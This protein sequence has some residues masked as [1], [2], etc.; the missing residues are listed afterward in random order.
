MRKP[1]LSAMAAAL[2]IASG[3]SAQGSVSSGST[4]FQFV[5][6][7]LGTTSGNANLLF[8]SSSAFGTEQLF[9][10]GWSYNQ[11]LGTSN[12]LFSGLDTPTATYIGNTA[13]PNWNNAGAGATGFARWNAVM[14]IVL[15]EIAPTPG[16][17]VPGQARVD[18]TLTFTSNA[19]NAANAG[20]AGNVTFNL[21]HDLDF[22]IVGSGG[23]SANGDTF[24]VL[25]NGAGGSFIGRAFDASGSNYA[26]FLAHG[27][28]RYEFNTGSALR[29]R[30]GAVS[31]GTGTGSLTN[32]V[33][34]TAADWASTDGAA[35]FQWTTT[36]APG[37]S[38]AVA[39]SFTINSPVPE[40]G[41][42]ALMLAGG[43]LVA[44]LARRRVRAAG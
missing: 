23:S 42:W 37:A 10:F 9:R 1:A 44:G 36:L 38:C 24:R 34:T 43:V 11:G 29:T 33:G 41:S 26:E 25:D 8:G 30:L 40:P 20:N 22:D 21:F 14:R 2:F 35:A 7:P 6:A 17:S 4:F 27:A 12:R 13:T 32:A 28:A 19:A 5:G 39:S 3:A 15:T 16:G 18:T 31:S